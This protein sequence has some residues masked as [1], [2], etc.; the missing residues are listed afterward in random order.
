MK[1]L[2]EA[3]LR[4]LG[5]MTPGPEEMKKAWDALK[6]GL[7]KEELPTSRGTTR[8][9]SVDEFELMP[10][11]REDVWAFKHCDTRNYLFVNKG[12]GK[13]VIYKSSKPFFKGEFDLFSGPSPT[14]P[15]PAF[16]KARMHLLNAMRTGPA[17]VKGIYELIMAA[18]KGDQFLLHAIDAAL[19]AALHDAGAQAADRYKRR[20]REVLPVMKAAI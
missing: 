9:A 20:V 11:E 13:L 2:I 14:V 17:E 3:Q 10:T 19:V 7:S 5:S 8:K 1:D 16:S 12:T 6:K 4:S 18:G 15:N